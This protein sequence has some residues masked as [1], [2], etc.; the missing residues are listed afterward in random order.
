MS[1][2]LI[3]GDARRAAVPH[4]DGGA[5]VGGQGR[6]DRER[7]EVLPESRRVENREFA[8][9][10]RRI[11][12]SHA[13]RVAEGDLEDLTEMLDVARMVDDAIDEAVAGLRAQGWSWAKI[14]A[15]VGITKQ[16]AQERWRS[17]T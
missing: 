8:A 11:I 16:S 10:V 6:P 9:F 1:G 3:L 13:R 17:S 4:P 5:R 2:A 15:A 7:D 14:G 12:R